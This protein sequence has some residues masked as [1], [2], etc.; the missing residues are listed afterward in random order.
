MPITLSRRDPAQT[1][2]PRSA[3][4]RK[5]RQLQAP[6]LLWILPALVV[7]V[8]L[9]YYCIGYTG[10]ISTWDWDGI[11]PDPTPVGLDNYRR[12]AGDPVFWSSLEHTIAF[13]VF[14]FAGQTVLGLLFAVILHSN[15]RF[16]AVYKVLIF[17]PVV[18]APAVVAPVFRQ[19]LAPDGQFNW[20]LEHIGLGFLAQPWIA[21]SS[22]ALGAV[23]V[24][25]IW[26]GTGFNFVLYYAAMSQIDQSLIEAARIDG[27]GNV[28][29]IANI[30]WPG[31]RGTTIALAML[32]AISS[33]KTFDIPYLVTGAVGGPNHST[34]FLGTY[35]YRETIP[36][37]DVGYGAALSI[38]LLVLA[39]LMAVLLRLQSRERK[40]VG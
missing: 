36:N 11:S 30:I 38:V 10:L 4:N 22:T 23:I 9:L 29:I 2:G 17:L 12:L 18:L 35:I 8:A 32:A 5:R 21:Q 33:L 14:T 25:S 37:F 27:A 31:L 26:Q 40:V 15:L 16:G 20:V 13:F 19:M 3:D 28:R 34:E 39:L 24:I 1:R 6:G 7:S